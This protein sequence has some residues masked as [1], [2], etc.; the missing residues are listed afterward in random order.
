MIGMLELAET[1]EFYFDAEAADRPVRFIERFCRHYEG[2]FAG[3]PFLLHPIQKRIIGDLYGWKWKKTGYRRF[4]DCYFEAAVG[5]GKSPLLAGLGLYGLIADGEAGAQVYSLAS[6]YGQARVVFESAK[7]FVNASPELARRLDVVDREIRYHPKNSI[8]RIVSGRGPGAGCRP[9]L[10]LGDEVHEWNGPGAY[11]ALRDR[12]FK[13]RQPLLLA[14]TNAG[15]SRA[16]F[17]WELREKAIAALE[18][19]GEQTLYPIIMAA[20]EDAQ[21]DDPSAWLAANPLLGVTIDQEKVAAQCTEAMK[22]PLEETHFRR[23]YMGICPKVGAGRWLD[24]NLWDI[25]TEKVPAIPA[26]APLYVGFD[27]SQ[28]DDLCAVVYIWPTTDRFIIESHFWIPQ[29]TAE[30]YRDKKSIPYID[31]ERQGHITL[32]PEPTVSAT[33]RRGIAKSIIDRTK[34]RTIKA[35][36][37]DRYKADETVAALEAAGLTCVPIPQGYSL[38]PGCQELDRRLKEGSISIIPNPVLRFCAENT[39][40]KTDDRGNIWPAKPNAKGRYAGQRQ[41]KID[42][43]TALVTGLVEAR[44]HAF[45]AATKNWKGTLCLG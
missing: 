26:D 22:D 18:G 31:W 39:E 33:V 37:Y 14:A 21:S 29:V 11:Q 40:I 16:S 13:R 25:A 28:C 36:C 41:A 44:K 8:W 9:S 12:M 23:L 20:D 17:C 24:L 34:G 6:N 5:A 45:P 3:E 4:T 35:V 15:Q 2:K 10:I 32:L 27:L 19:T 43:I 7:K 42:G 1:D 38:N 30:Y